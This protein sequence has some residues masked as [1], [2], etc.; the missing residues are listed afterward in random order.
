MTKLS[1]TLSKPSVAVL[2]GTIAVTIGFAADQQARSLKKTAPAPVGATNPPVTVESPK[3]EISKKPAMRATPP[4]L[5][6]SALAPAG[7]IVTPAGPLSVGGREQQVAVP[8]ASVL[9]A[10]GSIPANGSNPVGRVIPLTPQAEIPIEQMRYSVGKII[11]NYK[12]N[13]K[14]AKLPTE[15]DILNS[16]VSLL[17]GEGGFYA[18]PQPDRN[19]QFIVRPDPAIPTVSHAVA[20]MAPVKGKPQPTQPLKPVAEGLKEVKFKLSDAGA[21]RMMSNAALQVVY[22][23][24]VS[25]LNESGIIGVY[26]TSNLDPKEGALETVD[27]DTMQRTT[28]VPGADLMI[29]LY[30]SE[31]TH[32]RTVFRPVFRGTYQP[33]I[34]DKTM[35]DGV[36]KD[37]MHAWILTNSPIQEGTIDKKLLQEYLS[38]LNRFPGRRVDSAINATEQTGKVV[39]DYIIR[40]QKPYQLYLQ[41]GN[42]G[43]AATGEIRNRIGLDVKQLAK[44]DDILRFEYVTTDGSSYNSAFLSYELALKR[45]DYLKLRT[46]LSTGSYSAED[47]GLENQKFSGDSW[48]I[49]SAL[50]WTPRY[51]RDYPLDLSLGIEWLNASVE[52]SSRGASSADFLLPYIGIG[53]DRNT[54]I[55]SLSA[56]LELQLGIANGELDNLGRADTDDS[57]LMAKWNVSRSFYVEPWLRGKHWGN[58]NP[59]PIEAAKIGDEPDRDLRNAMTKAGANWKNVRLAHEIALSTRGQYVFGDKRLAP[60]LEAVVGG[61]YS[62]R[63]YPESFT[64][65]DTSVLASAEYRLHIPRLLKPTEVSDAEQSLASLRKQKADEAAAKAVPTTKPVKV[66]V[67]AKLPAPAAASVPAPQVVA[68]TKPTTDPVESKRK[69][70]FRPDNIGGSADWD[71][72]FRAFAD[73]GQTTNN[74]I[75]PTTEADRTMLGIGAGVEMQLFAPVH[76]TLRADVGFAMLDEVDLLREP[77]HA[78]D[79]RIHVSGTLAW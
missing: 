36:K 9:P 51:W 79:S 37:P 26:I 47:V 30:V 78:G 63:G 39:L 23:K 44:K 35:P 60:Q 45:P 27:L 55:A 21:P 76:F 3:V 8:N 10:E 4:T 73:Y 1:Q 52:D 64:P 59:P 57:F 70:R 11:V 5:S 65:G 40:E 48:S 24:I 72:I 77:V 43:T 13:V 49:G 31:V 14:S 15:K 58:S 61:A 71:L 32:V 33:K 62:V 68:T 18:K 19:N 22:E 69:F 16:E 67:E 20:P 28:W 12:T 25:R 41:S 50:T 17:Q 75:S 34:N 29:G 46:Y 2:V 7:A 56:S 53:T 54:D 38:R 66:G 42:T 6:P 74:R